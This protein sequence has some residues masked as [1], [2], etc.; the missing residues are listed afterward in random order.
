MR[1]FSKTMDSKFQKRGRMVRKGKK[2]EPSGKKKLA[3]K[4]SIS[5]HDDDDDDSVDSF[6]N[7]RGLIDYDYDSEESD[8]SENKKK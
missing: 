6:G 2:E 5:H 8:D 1:W 7:I 3:P 4:K